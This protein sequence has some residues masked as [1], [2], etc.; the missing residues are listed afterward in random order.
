MGVALFKCIP[1]NFVSLYEI[2]SS[3]NGLDPLTLESRTIVT[4]DSTGTHYY[5]YGIHPSFCVIL[6]SS[7]IPYSLNLYAEYY[8]CADPNLYLDP[9]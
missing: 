3:Q 4:I 7:D 2:G 1:G 9:T 6:C 5:R 8:Q